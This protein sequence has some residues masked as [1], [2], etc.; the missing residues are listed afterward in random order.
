MLFNEKITSSA[1]ALLSKDKHPVLAV[2][3]SLYGGTI[4]VYRHVTINYRYPT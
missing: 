3:H 1:P 2:V 4:N